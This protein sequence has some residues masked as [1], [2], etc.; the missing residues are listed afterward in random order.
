MNPFFSLIVPAYNRAAQLE[1]ALQS[2]R[3]QHFRDYEVIVVD[4]CSSDNSATVARRFLADGVRLVQR[5]V[6]GG[7]CQARN[8]GI[9]VARGQWCVM[10]DSD[11]SFRHE[12]AL[13]RLT[14]WCRT[15]PAEVGN[16]TS[17]CAW[18]NGWLTPRPVPPAEMDYDGYLQWLNR[19]EISEYFNCVRREVFA[20]VRYAES[21]A[22]ETS[23]HLGL[24]KR[25]RLR[26]FEEPLVM[27]HTD[28]TNR[29]TTGK[30]RAALRRMLVD[31]PDK[32]ANF[33]SIISEHGAALKAHAPRVHGG[34]LREAMKQALLAGARREALAYWQAVPPAH[35]DR[36]LHP[37]LLLGLIHR[38]LLAWANTLKTFS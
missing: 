38:V 37:I 7:P 13:G 17:A 19:V 22:W 6:N 14:D 10:L 29:L 27:V 20:D 25:W 15:M 3:R 26:F 16:C 36:R 31:A 11:F 18:D 1:R 32:R 23:F 21:R 28:A 33:A 8:S 30:G 12:G 9:A 5:A 34:L 2:M 24:A 35:R 4:D